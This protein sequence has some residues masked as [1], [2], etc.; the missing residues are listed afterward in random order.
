M[1]GKGGNIF[2][3]QI[4]GACR[5]PDKADNGIKSCG[6]AGPVGAKQT[7]NGAAL[8]LQVN[9]IHHS[10]RAVFFDNAPGLQGGTGFHYLFLL[11]VSG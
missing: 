4:N 11:S 9:L 6:L 10:A 7:D 8:H 1:D 5:G 3:I 2:A